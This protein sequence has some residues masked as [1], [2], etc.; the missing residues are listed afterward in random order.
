MLACA[1]LGLF[2]GV[3][4]RALAAPVAL[5][6][7]VT[8]DVDPAT[9]F[10]GTWAAEWTTDGALESW[11]GVNA[12]VTVSGGILSGATTT[13]DGRVE[14]TVIASGPDLDLGFN[15]F[16]ELRLQVPANYAGVIQIFYGTTL[17]T[18]F[19]ATRQIDIPASLI[20]KDGSFHT[21]RLNLG[22]EVYWRGTL[23]DLRIDPVDGAGTSG[24][25][26]ALDYVR[27]GD[28]PGAPVYQPRV[29]TECP[30]AGGLTPGGAPTGPNQ[31]VSSLESKRFRLL[32][33]DAVA[34][35]G[36]WT[37]TMARA[38]LRNA[39]ECWQVFVNKM[40][41][42]EPAWAM[43]AGTSGTR[44]KLNITTWHS[45]YWAGGDGSYARLNITP[46][47]LRENPPSGV[48]PHELMHC[49]QFHNTSGNVP[50]A[51]WEGHAN[52]GRERYN[53][54][55]RLLYPANQRSGIDP[56]YLRCAH[57]IIGHGRDYYLSWPLFLY[58]DENPDALPDLGEGTNV[59]LWQQTAAGQYPLTLLENLTPTTSLK[60]IV[61]YFARRGATYNYAYKTD[62]QAALASFG[63]PLDNAATQRWQFADLAR[64]ADDPNWWRV[65]YE[66]A[67]MQGAY[68]LH[69]LVPTT[70]GVAG[71]VV[72]VNFRGLPDAARG[73]DWRASFIVISDSG[74]ERY[75][76]LWA[77]GENSVTLAANENKLYLSVA[78]TPAVFHNPEFD[79]VTHPYRSH[80]SKTRFP[81]ELHVAGA[82][83]RQRDNGTSTA[84]LVQHANGGGWKASTATVA[85]TVYLAPG[86]RVFN[87]A[88]IS[89]NVRI[90][91]NALVTG[92]PVISGNAT[93]SGRA[94][95]RGGAINGF[96]KI[97]DWALV[98]GGT[99]TGN[100]RV[101]EHANIKGGTLQDL[102]TAKGTA[103]SNTGVLS[104]NAIID[105]DYGDF[106]SGRDIANSVAFGHVPYVGVPDS[107]LRALPAGLYAAYDFAAAHD[108][109][110]FDQY[111][112]TDAF[113]LGSPAWVSADARRK[114]FLAFDGATQAVALDR[115][116]ADLRDFTFTA[117]VKPLGGAASQPVLWLGASSA[118]RLFLTPDDGAGRAKFSIANGG[119]EQTLLASAPLPLGVWT[120]VAVTLNG[121]TGALYVN[122]ALAA[123][124][125][126]TIRPD[127]LLAANTAAYSQHNYLARS[128]GSLL[129]A[130]RGALDDV[131]FY[132]AA[133]SAADIAAFQPA[134]ALADAGTL[135]VDLR[136]TDASAGAATWTNTAAGSALGNF[137]RTGSPIKNPADGVPGVIFNGVD[138]AYTSAGLTPADLHGASD[139]SIEVWAY[140]PALAD[141]ETMLS[142]G[143]RGADASNMAFNFGAHT[144][145][146]AVTHWGGGHD[147]GWGSATPGARAWRH[148]VYTYDGATT[149]RVYIDGVL[150]NTRTLASPLS[151]FAAQPLNLACQRASAG[152]ARS[153]F[154]S[155]YL[156]RVRVHGGVLSP[157]Q[158]AGN[159]SLGPD[160]APANATPALAA[161]SDQTLDYGTGAVPLSLTV[162]DTNTAVG[163][164]ALTAAS[165]NSAFLPAA[166][167]VFAGTA[168]SRTATLTPALP[169]GTS[170][171]TL[172]VSDGAATSS[173]TFTFT[174]LTQA[175]T[176]RRQNFGSTLDSGSAADT[177]DTD[178]D[179]LAN[180]LERALGGNPNAPDP[181]LLP[182]IDPGAP[183]LNL[184]YPRS[185]A[186]NDLLFIVQE[187]PDLS[188]DS[189]VP[190][191]GTSTVLNE[192]GTAQ[193]IRFTVPLDSA[194][195][196]FLRLQ[197]TAP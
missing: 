1:A 101:L 131:R 115:S 151:T 71:R 172:T 15:D 187:S 111:G 29:S 140:N 175:E 168:A 93:I 41:Y 42:R 157:T 123:G 147:V 171:V 136:A 25:S 26:F 153:H 70:T 142:W 169:S 165:T 84:G 126:I 188:P 48:I 91:D 181:Q 103:A 148:L 114:G 182:V 129:P 82:T 154:F 149:V 76:T 44:Y 110:V 139:R 6:S 8:V 53:E 75:G 40:G 89:G 31:A 9:T 133:L 66:M 196:K 24:M 102:A 159:Y 56:T 83:P 17:T 13:T 98:E 95:I 2:V 23:R 51:W 189:W 73:A 33:N 173:R 18:G 179:G 145:W 167:I 150:A 34:A 117:W 90:E 109:R 178:G 69:E 194:P 161:I 180:L 130:F 80:P 128:E 112:A 96:A 163:A 185:K 170:T 100:A 122:G 155:G 59:K 174:L 104:G 50:G 16:L 30:A 64:R 152:G 162:S 68:A 65:P 183:L 62:I 160:G 49:F 108:S 116:I 28:E 78:A 88:N 52:Y 195:R 72:T 37:A 158:V 177:A 32:W 11:A 107:H 74:T 10:T 5:P 141:E 125:P 118:R 166:N 85:S 184:V 186:A 127:Q 77:S 97:R 164:L 46:D 20:P 3:A 146:G 191:A 57:Q 94:W 120:H 55:F 86:A 121:S 144:T 134:A 79:E 132:G 7:G 67:P 58:L 36:S 99:I 14:R 39:E 193:T 81:Y 63:A 87:T 192:T 60:D 106:F 105:G 35:N 61:G 12:G 92:S 124:G 45:G 143:Y 138:Q 119:A 137:T 156:N 43:G 197:I 38:T 22:L 27:V 190:A 176:W 21:Y 47:G 135:H 113:T 19:A 4:A 54:H